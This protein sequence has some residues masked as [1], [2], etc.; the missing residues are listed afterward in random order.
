MTFPATPLEVR[1]DLMVDGA[2]S[3]ITS[4][5]L[6]DDAITISRGRADEATQA[7]PSTCSLSLKNRN[8]TYSPRNPTSS[9]YGKIGRNTRMRVGVGSPPIAAAVNGLT[10]TSLAA[11]SVTAEASGSLMCVWGATPVGNIT[12]PGGFSMGTEQDGTAST[13][14]GGYKAV[15]A[16]ATGTSTATYS[17]AATD[18]VA[19]SVAVP[20]AAV[21]AGFV[22]ISTALGGTCSLSVTSCA[23]GDYLLVVQGWSTDPYGQMT[24]FPELFAITS[25]NFMLVA[26]TGASAGPRLRAWIYRVPTGATATQTIRF[27]NRPRESG[28]GDNYARAWRLTGVTD[29]YVRHVGE[30]SS[31]PQTW[32]LSGADVRARITSSGILRR[33]SQGASPLQSALTRHIANSPNVRGYWPCEEESDATSFSSPLAGVVPGLPLGA[34]TLAAD[35]GWLGSEPLPTWQSA[36]FRATIPPYASSGELFAGALYAMPVAGTANNA[37]LIAVGFSGGT[38]SRAIIEY[39]TGGSLAI[40]LMD[41]SNA[42]AQNSAF[43]FNFDGDRF[44]AWLALT[45]N[46]ANIDWKI[47]AIE[48][49]AGNYSPT[50]V[51]GTGTTAAQTF[52]SANS[53]TAGV[54]G[55]NNT[56]LSL[57][58]AVTI[59]HVTV[60]SGVQYPFRSDISYAYP[61]LVGWFA[62]GAP[63]RITRLCR[64]EGIDCQGYYAD[65][66]TPL[67]PQRPGALIDLLREAADSDMGQVYDP[68]GWLG[69]GYRSRDSRQS[70]AADL[71]LSY[72]GG[73]VA[74]PFEPVDDDQ[75]VRNDVTVTRIGGSSARSQLTTGPLSTLAP[76]NGVGRYDESVD[77]SLWRDSDA[78][79]AAGWRVHL[80][81]SDEARYPSVSTMLHKSPSLITTY[82]ALDVLD[83]LS[84]TGLPAWLPPGPAEVMIEGYTETLTPFTWD[85]TF[86]ASPAGPW[87][88]AAQDY[89]EFSRLDSADSTLASAA[90][91]GATRLDVVTADGSPLWITTAGFAAQ[92]P[93]NATVGGE[94]VTV[95]AIAGAV[96]DTFTRTVSNGWGTADSGQAWTLTGTASYWS[97]SGTRGVFTNG[98]AVNVEG[99]QEV[100]GSWQN[101]DVTAT[102]VFQSLPTGANIVASLWAH[103]GSSA[104]IKGRLFHTT[105]DLLNIDVLGTNATVSLGSANGIIAGVNGTPIKVRMK[106]V[107]TAVKLKAWLASVAEPVFWHVEVTD[108]V[109]PAAGGFG[110][111]GLRQTSNTNVNPVMEFDDIAMS[112]P[113]AWT[114]T[115]SV[116][117]VVKAQSAGAQIRLAKPNYIGLWV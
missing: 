96:A 68:K 36:G 97:T 82:A 114:V 42:I 47:C 7:D 51:V 93:F 45:Q 69:I 91:S 15:S 70:R 44:F 13:W 101:L 95:T 71:T 65:T 67:G 17:T 108:T 77:L 24:E 28:G 113:Q 37:N 109:T 8:G 56:S 88:V 112:N 35:G 64:E 86:N 72:T 107:G 11:P 111:S 66:G 14:N 80:G 54:E 20:G 9:L 53:V 78:A 16:G 61:A 40:K 92:F 12:G 48:L 6:V 49:N 5:V 106:I 105:A 55:D 115:R 22:N 29:Y 4:D 94:V 73:Q 98:G 85:A 31:W 21:A 81:T 39:R 41:R 52:G 62:E 2:W 103:R 99:I 84:I 74:A 57:S 18:G 46:G 27:K 63:F 79:D 104:Q 89:G 75:L 58:T 50:Q 10:G 26:D 19:L 43:A 1:V 38:I 30:V 117:G 33:L 116:N 90:T 83:Q 25:S 100:S 110:I 23:A 60:S 34:P 87:R 32:D 76:P 3:N 102:V 59:G